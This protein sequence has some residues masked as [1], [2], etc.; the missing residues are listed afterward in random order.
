MSYV[1]QSSCEC[2]KQIF[3]T[4]ERA[5]FVAVQMAVTFGR[6][7]LPYQCRMH[8]RFWHLH[9]ANRHNDIRQWKWETEGRWR[10]RDGTAQAD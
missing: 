4:Q 7:M 2:G 5:A 6:P 3:L 10:K 9:T 1:Y 8:D